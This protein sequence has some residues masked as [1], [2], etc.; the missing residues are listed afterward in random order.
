M[1]R[2]VTSVEK[3]IAASRVTGTREWAASNVNVDRGCEHDCRYCYA[4]SMAIRFGRATPEDWRCPTARKQVRSRYG[5]RSGPIMIPTT[6][7]ITPHNVARCIAELLKM[8]EPGNRVLIVSKPSLMC[9]RELC[10]A[11][12][13][14]RHLV[15]YRFTIGSADDQVLQF[16][17][18]GAPGFAERLAAL[19][20]AYGQ[21][22][23]TSVSC[24][25][26]LDGD[27]HAVIAAVRPYVT[28]SIWLGRANRLGPILALNCP[29]DDEVRKAGR[30]LDAL[31]DDR[32]VL[33]LYERY[34]SDP[35]I[36]WKDSIKRVVGIAQ[37]TTAGGDV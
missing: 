28:H 34:A 32:A 12:E 8:L 13:P 5:K 15:L 16:W 3:A 20:H 18:P 4:M 27:I 21:G 22:F 35:L 19:E 26:M 31:W 30:E 33:E 14:Y 24:E 36:R 6:H 7:D 23:E 29:G 1:K 37:P 11:L 25:P 10:K 2:K 9:I 17:E